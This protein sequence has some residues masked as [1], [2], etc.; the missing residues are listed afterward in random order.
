MW[1][2]RARKYERKQ[3]QRQQHPKLGGCS[4]SLA[5]QQAA[6]DLLLSAMNIGMD[7]APACEIIEGE[8][9]AEGVV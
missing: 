5:S 1:H 8:A 6:S 7:V 4:I 9:A 2:L 3:Q